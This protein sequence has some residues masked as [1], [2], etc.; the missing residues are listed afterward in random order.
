[1]LAGVMRRQVLAAA[2]R[3]GIEAEEH[4]VGR[5]ELY[6]AEE[7]FLT[8]ALIEL[9]PIA[10]VDGRP[11]RRGELWRSLLAAAADDLNS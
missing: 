7:V 9:L 8:N 11:C 5:E 6:T 3:L 1:V 10:A 4:A 2:R